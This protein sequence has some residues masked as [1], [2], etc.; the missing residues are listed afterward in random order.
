MNH[1][2]P[3]RKR[4][5]LVTGGT[6][7][8]GGR[9]VERLYLEHG[10]EVRVLVKNHGR[11]AARIGRLPIQLVGG[12]VNDEASVSNAMQ[13][14]DY[15]FHCAFG[16]EG[17]VKAQYRVNVGGIQSILSAAKQHRPKR[18]VYISTMAVYGKSSAPTIH[19]QLPYGDTGDSYGSSKRKAEEVARSYS[20]QHK[21]SLSMVQPAIV[22]GPYGG[23]WT[24][25]PL[26]ILRNQ[27][28]LLPREGQGTC[29]LVHVD[30]VIDA[31]LLCAT[32]PA[33]DG[34][35]FLINGDSITWRE[36][37]GYFERMIG[38]QAIQLAPNGSFEGGG[39]LSEVKQRI[40]GI[41]GE[42]AA[43]WSE[44]PNRRDHLA[45]VIRLTGIQAV[46]RYLPESFYK[47]VK[48]KGGGPK[49]IIHQPRTESVP[50]I[51]PKGYELY[52][53]DQQGVVSSQKAKDLLNYTPRIRPE[54]GMKG[55]Q[56][57][58]KWA[59]LL[60]ESAR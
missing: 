27:N 17:G 58:A 54:E 14:C 7:F 45:N 47:I 11:A 34:E 30:D 37:Y 13:G 48:G 29:N 46:Q 4:T 36:F 6:G 35:R 56:A 31:M 20:A 42:L 50:L 9:L 25:G 5:I 51:R 40:R 38:R 57:W 16:N 59:N 12:E 18:V 19:E 24:L 15:V 55:V 53:Y 21:I 60:P 52:L 39:M 10:A 33:A 44:S 2:S 3:F 23:S 22:Y 49:R 1:D 8:I 41:K 26:G 32:H 43:I 28:L